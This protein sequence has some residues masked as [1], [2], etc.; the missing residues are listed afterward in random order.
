MMAKFLDEEIEMRTKTRWESLVVAVSLA[1]VFA[2]CEAEHRVAQKRPVVPPVLGR[3]AL[4]SD[5]QVLLNNKAFF[6]R[7][8][9]PPSISEMVQRAGKQVD[10][11]EDT[12]IIERAKMNKIDADL[13]AA[14]DELTKALEA[15]DDSIKDKLNGWRDLADEKVTTLTDA[16][17]DDQIAK[18]TD[19]LAKANVR[20]VKSMGGLTDDARDILLSLGD[21]AAQCARLPSSDPIRASLST[22]IDDLN[23]K[24]PKNLP[25]PVLE[26]KTARDSALVNYEGSYRA[27]YRRPELLAQL[28]NAV[29]ALPTNL[30]DTVKN[31]YLALAAIFDQKEAQSQ[32]QYGIAEAGFALVNSIIGST[33]YFE[34]RLDRVSFSFSGSSVKVTLV[35]FPEKNQTLSTAD[36][37]VQNVSYEEVGGVLRFEA[38]SPSDNGRYYKF[39][40]SR[41]RTEIT[42]GRIFYQ[43][44]MDY[45]QAGG[46]CEPKSGTLLRHGV[47]KLATSN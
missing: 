19:E 4:D 33:D 1:A 32:L 34:N 40:I 25:A 35:N 7:E 13:S 39:R 15:M 2:G 14:G 16:Q 11:N 8:P 43:G 30:P 29:S 46:N 22:Q 28:A 6:W 42:D 45:C 5:A 9:L 21:L 36:G 17:L 27:K 10:L 12:A 37:T 47:V 31:S 38:Y 41:T 18:T 44:D 23:K 24:L 26:A 20:L 3:F